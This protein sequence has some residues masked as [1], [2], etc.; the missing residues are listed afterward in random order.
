MPSVMFKRPEEMDAGVEPIIYMRE[1]QQTQ[2]YPVELEERI[3][4]PQA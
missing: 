3:T 1:F 2:R 4:A